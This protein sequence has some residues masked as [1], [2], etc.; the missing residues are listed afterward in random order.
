MFFKQRGAMFGLDARISLAILSGLSVVGGYSLTQKIGPARYVALAKDIRNVDAAVRQMQTDMRVFYFDAVET[1]KE[2]LALLDVEDGTDDAVKA[3]YHPRWKGP[4]LN[5]DSASHPS[6]GDF[7][8]I[9]KK[10][11]HTTD[12]VY[13]DD[14]YVWLV[15][16]N[17][18]DNFLTKVNDIIDE[19]NGEAPEASPSD[20]GLLHYNT[21]TDTLYYRSVM[22]RR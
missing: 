12:C 9:R 21:T 4:Y 19:K 2:F 11:D 15:L 10:G 20:S 5:M 3:A 22:R 6:F 18:P 14:C 17:V 8:L 7:S 13:N 16:D 1:N